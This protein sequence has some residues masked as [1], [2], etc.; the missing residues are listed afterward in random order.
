M[1][2]DDEVQFLAKSQR[3]F[4][5]D[6][7]KKK[8]GKSLI[9]ILI[10]LIM[11]AATVSI[12][13]MFVL[14]VNQVFG[15]GMSTAIEDQAFIISNRLAYLSYEP[16]RG[17]IVLTDTNIYRII[18]MPGETV[19]IYG[20]HIYINEKMV[21]EEYEL[22]NVLT[23]PVAGHETMIV[24]QNAYY[25][26]CDNRKCYDD[27]RLGM[28]LSRDAIRSKVLFA[29]QLPSSFNLSNFQL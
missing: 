19:E 10:T 28:A 15:T 26:L 8:L 17:D 9:S 20:G 21:Q 25:V 22:E 14:D 6:F 13:F 7:K 4:K 18:G 1:Y 24:P 27:S 3:A 12:I 16:R 5:R 29:F 11:C 2:T 23:Y